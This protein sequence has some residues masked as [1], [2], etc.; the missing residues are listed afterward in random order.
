M[1]APLTKDE[2][3][4]VMLKSEPRR[5]TRRHYFWGG[6]I[7]WLAESAS[8]LLLAVV[9]GLT[10]IGLGVG[11]LWGMCVIVGSCQ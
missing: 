1:T 3:W 11:L 7:Y 9:I 6:V 2:L 5:H 10:G 8:P 4:R